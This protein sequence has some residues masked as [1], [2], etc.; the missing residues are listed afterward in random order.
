MSATRNTGA[1]AEIL[2]GRRWKTRPVSG[3]PKTKSG[4]PKK[5][6]NTAGVIFKLRG[7]RGHH[8]PR[9]M[10]P[11]PEEVEVRRPETGLSRGGRYPLAGLVVCGHCGKRM[12]GCTNRYKH[13][14]NLN[15][16][17][18]YVCTSYNLSGTSAAASTPFEKTC[19]CLSLSESFRGT[20]SPPNGWCGWRPSCAR[21][22][23]RRKGQ[24]QP[25]TARLQGLLASVEQLGRRPGRAPG[26]STTWTCSTRRLTGLRTERDWSPNYEPPRPGENPTSISTRRSKMP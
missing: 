17:R 1:A 13:R 8:R 19:C 26:Q 11:R 4:R 25:D 3:I 24:A 7:P 23:G 18:R 6:I 2:S 14:K 20:T 9:I 21:R 5:Q 15:A 22:L 12:H 10:G 16:Y